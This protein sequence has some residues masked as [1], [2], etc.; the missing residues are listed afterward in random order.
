[1]N[2]D[3]TQIPNFT[4]IL[5]E[6]A[7]DAIVFADNAGIISIWNTAAKKLFGFTASEALGANLNIIIPERFRE[8]HWRGFE[9]ALAN[10]TTKYAGQVLPTRALCSDGSQIYVELSFAIVLDPKGD[11]LGA[12]AHARKKI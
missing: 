9:R 2:A 12:I 3:I 5:I 8:A 4:D 7:P 1:M 10:H 11:V 6:Q